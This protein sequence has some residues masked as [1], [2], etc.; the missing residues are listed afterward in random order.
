VQDHDKEVDTASM[1]D[2]WKLISVLIPSIQD[3]DLDPNQ[4]LIFIT[5]NIQQISVESVETTI[6]LKVIQAIWNFS[7]TICE[8]AMPDN[9]ATLASIV[10]ERLPSDSAFADERLL[11][12]F[13]LVNL[14]REN[15]IQIPIL[16]NCESALT[17][18]Q[19]HRQDLLGMFEE[20]SAKRLRAGTRIKDRKAIISKILSTVEL[21]LLSWAEK[22]SVLQH[23]LQV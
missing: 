2:R 6:L 11:W 3:A 21:V 5:N 7:C 8:Q 23:E 14:I 4:K 1:T 15:P 22:C 16:S 19:V 13:Y 10:L 12:S 20:I 18:C 9:Q 17:Y